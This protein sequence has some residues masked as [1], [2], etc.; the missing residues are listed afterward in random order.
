MDLLC[1]H[2]LKSTF[3]QLRAA[4]LSNSPTIS[5]PPVC[6][7]SLHPSPRS[8]SLSPWI[9][10]AR[11]RE[12]NRE[13]N[14]ISI[15]ARHSHPLTALSILRTRKAAGFIPL[16]IF[17]GQRAQ[18]GSAAALGFASGRRRPS[19]MTLRV[20]WLIKLSEPQGALTCVPPACSCTG[21]HR[22]LQ[23]SRLRRQAADRCF[24]HQQQLF[25]LPF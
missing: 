15:P 13:H 22:N 2:T 12:Q 21:T 3:K 6:S 18:I 23:R 14:A 16:F 7:L 1:V 10:T 4:S 24:Q 8:P 19:E 11:S 5:T 20:N 17:G 9:H 25:Y